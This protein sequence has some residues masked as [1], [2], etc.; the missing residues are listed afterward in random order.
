MIT[1]LVGDVYICTTFKLPTHSK[2]IIRQVET[3]KLGQLFKLCTC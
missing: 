2:I 3:V 1:I